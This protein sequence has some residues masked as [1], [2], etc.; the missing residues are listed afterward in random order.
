MSDWHVRTEMC[1]SNWHE[2]ARPNKSSEYK[3]RACMIDLERGLSHVSGQYVFVHIIFSLPIL[4]NLRTSM[5]ATT[6]FE[7]SPS[8]K[9]RS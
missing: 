1:Q 3:A 2:L 7:L 4:A 6:R 8:V 9:E 5:E